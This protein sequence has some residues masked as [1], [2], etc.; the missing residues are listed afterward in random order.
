MR[1][2]SKRWVLSCAL[3]TFLGTF[4]WMLSELPVTSRTLDAV[5][6]RANYFLLPG[7]LFDFLLHGWHVHDTQVAPTLLGSSIFYS[8]V[9][10]GFIT[11]RNRF[12]TVRV[13]H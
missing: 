1:S 10:Y 9:I 12:R 8:A 2:P 5:S 11:L 4:P 6:T 7:I 3:G 13:S